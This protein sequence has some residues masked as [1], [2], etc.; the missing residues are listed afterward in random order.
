M[1]SEHSESHAAQ[2]HKQVSP[3]KLK[4][5]LFTVSSSRFRDKSTRDESGEIALHLCSAAGH[6]CTHK[7]IDDDKAMIRLN[8]LKSLYEDDSEAAILLGGTGLAPRDVTI[9]A[10]AP[11]MDKQ[12]DG[13]GEI[14]RRLSYDSVGSPALM[15]RAIGGIIGRKPVFCLPGSPDA[16]RLG[17]ELILKE[18]PHA[19]FIASSKP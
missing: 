16:V 13:F 17:I 18:L 3:Q 11:L 12:L 2:S 8:L 4:L 15:S 14:F 5:A 10:V 19:V 1:R 7:V 6:E 9:E